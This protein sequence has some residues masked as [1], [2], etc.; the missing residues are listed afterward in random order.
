MEE[1][2]TANQ[3]K[4]GERKAGQGHRGSVR[5]ISEKNPRLGCLRR[6]VMR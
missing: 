5:T 4:S 6:L 3:S 1:Q 2:M